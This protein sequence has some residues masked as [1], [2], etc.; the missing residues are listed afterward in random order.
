MIRLLCL[1]LAEPHASILELIPR[2]SLR[3]E[4]LVPSATKGKQDLYLYHEACMQDPT[5]SAEAK[6]LEC[7]GVAR[8]KKEILGE[9]SCLVNDLKKLEPLFRNEK[10]SMGI[11]MC[12]LIG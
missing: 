4:R 9:R 7:L 12:S 1:R 10:N 6:K 2:N 11:I 8:E 5:G 3:I